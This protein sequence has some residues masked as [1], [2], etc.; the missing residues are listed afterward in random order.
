MATL[1]DSKTVI[2]AN[3]TQ[4]TQPP[5]KPTL[6]SPSNGATNVPIPVT[7]TW[8]SVAGAEVYRVVVTI[9]VVI[10]TSVDTVVVDMNVAQPTITLSNLQPNTT[11]KWRVKAINQYG[12][13]DW[14]DTWE[15]TTSAQ[16]APDYTA[17]F[18]MMGLVMVMG[19]V[20]S[21]MPKEQ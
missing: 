6:Q 17:L 2:I 10:G 19:I 16:A 7:L 3:V 5:G 13:S 21:M 18:S 1:L 12:E 20:S 4:V 15:F 8:S 9:S 14:S 11:Y